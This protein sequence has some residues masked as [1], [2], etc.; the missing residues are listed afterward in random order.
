LR[1]ETVSEAD[2]AHIPVLNKEVA[3]GVTME[4]VE[5]APKLTPPAVVGTV[6]IVT[7]AVDLLL[8]TMDAVELVIVVTVASEGEPLA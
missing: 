6:A 3:V 7:P 4:R 2:G 5:G 8:E 1:T